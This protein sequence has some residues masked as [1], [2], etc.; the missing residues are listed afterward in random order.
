MNKIERK[1]ANTYKYK[2]IIAV[3]TL[4]LLFLSGMVS[5]KAYALSFI[6][7]LPG[8]NESNISSNF[9]WRVLEGKRGFHSGLDIAA[10][11]Q[12]PIVAS[13]DGT[14]SHA[15]AKGTYGNL[16]EIDHGGG[17][18]TRYAHCTKILVSKGQQVRAGNTIALVGSTGHSTGPHLHFEVRINNS[19]KNPRNFVHSDPNQKPGE[20]PD[21]YNGQSGGGEN[22]SPKK[23]G[24]GYKTNGLNV[25]TNESFFYQGAPKGQ[26]SARNNTLGFI[27]NFIASI[28]KFLITLV[29][30]LIIKL[31][32]IGYASLFEVMITQTFNA[33]SGE[34][35]YIKRNTNSDLYVDPRRSVNVE[36][37]IYGRVELLNI[38]FFIDPIKANERMEG[39]TGTGQSIEEINR[40]AEIAGNAGIA[41]EYTAEAPDYEESVVG[42]LRK[43][44][45][46]LYY[47]VY[48]ISII[49]MLFM[50][51]AITIS[52]MIQQTAKKKAKLKEFLLDW[53]K[54]FG[55]L[56]FSVIYVFFIIKFNN[57]LLKILLDLGPKYLDD[58][59]LN[60]TA[61]IYETIRTRAYDNKFSIGVPAAILYLIL[62]WDTVKF[63]YIYIK[64]LV[65][66]MLL[67]ILGPVANTFQILSNAFNG[68]P[69]DRTSV[70]SWTKE[71]T[72]LVLLQTI[73]AALYTFI[74]IIVF[75][76]L[77]DISLINFVI[78][79]GLHSML[80][81]MPKYLKKIFKISD[82]TKS[83]VSD[84]IK[85]D[86]V[87]E[88][89]VMTNAIL[90]S[91]LT[92]ISTKNF[93]DKVKGIVG[94]GT[95]IATGTL[96]TV[97]GGI[98]RNAANF[99][100]FL[101]DAIKHNEK[102]E[103]SP[104]VLR[105]REQLLKAIESSFNNSGIKM[106]EDLKEKLNMYSSLDLSN[107]LND[108]NT[109]ENFKIASAGG[110]LEEILN[111]DPEFSKYLS[112]DKM[113]EKEKALKWGRVKGAA[114]NTKPYFLNENGQYRIFKPIKEY[115]LKTGKYEIVKP[116]SSEY[117]KKIGEAFG[118]EGEKFKED[119]RLLLNTLE[120]GLSAVGAAIAIP[121]LLGDLGNRSGFKSAAMGGL[122]LP[123][124]RTSK[125]SQFRSDFNHYVTPNKNL[126]KLGIKQKIISKMKF[127]KA[128]VSHKNAEKIL[129]NAE[130]E[131]LNLQ[132]SEIERA[133]PDISKKD[134]KRMK[135]ISVSKN[136]YDPDR[137]LGKT[138][139]LRREQNK[140]LEEI[141]A[142]NVLDME[143]DILNQSQYA[144]TYFEIKGDKKDISE[145]LNTEDIEEKINRNLE[146]IELYKKVIKIKE[147]AN[148]KLLEAN[149]YDKDKSVIKDINDK[150]NKKID[151]LLTDNLSK[152]EDLS[153]LSKEEIDEMHQ[154]TLYKI[155]S[156]DK[157][158][159]NKLIEKEEESISSQTFKIMLN[160]YKD[161]NITEILDDI[162]DG[163]LKNKFKQEIDFKNDLEIEED[164]SKNVLKLTNIYDETIEVE[165]LKIIGRKEYDKAKQIEE[166]VKNSIKKDK[167]KEILKENITE[168]QKAEKIKQ[169]VSKITD[170]DVYKDEN[171]NKYLDKKQKAILDKYISVKVNNA[172]RLKEEDINFVINT[173]KDN[174]QKIE[175]SVNKLHKKYMEEINKRTTIIDALKDSENQYSI[176]KETYKAKK[177]KNKTNSINVK[178]ERKVN[179]SKIDEEKERQKNL[180][181]LLNKFYKN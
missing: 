142:L 91:E 87:K 62:V 94:K 131:I 45:A 44:Y 174:S 97:G 136:Y 15:G 93:K 40:R 55:T 12:T 67:A 139:D 110:D 49:L 78:L 57:F 146:K 36:N 116:G 168:E 73:H 70:E 23:Y 112:Y 21:G 58:G 39:L 46:G 96:S 22:R 150:T 126:R 24:S 125:F 101:N 106:P 38:D 56:L 47:A 33:I 129:K 7:P 50:L 2:K 63:I 61:S 88:M 11:M 121:A 114:K 4:I 176:Y 52:S 124:K 173:W 167:I 53:L 72:Y 1:L 35:A 81:E 30:N 105:Q 68:K 163:N 85:S 153:T 159:L 86:P 103:Y 111:K 145:I 117:F 41:P 113:K 147:D 166:D 171:R 157:N 133:I 100:L 99:G 43:N 169:E 54:G 84:T 161:K 128:Y 122:L 74:M 8:K 149:L 132:Y 13:A 77:V 75:K 66:L 16:V 138:G 158:G 127:N 175:K 59:I 134:I 137:I 177:G 29:V 17:Y 123:D 80:Y 3:I 90:G 108:K 170:A 164:I 107:I 20:V 14:V 10:P 18:V 143:K 154:K 135:K 151:K 64:R 162:E 60:K 98:L 180:N 104:E 172:D 140:I 71:I 28:G 82:K 37:I 51:V 34:D 89:D 19:P 102:G 165:T 178:T 83:A 26:Y 148:K 48:G 25:I 179:K 9:G 109:L 95:K 65:Y 119:K 115:N 92:N 31:P 76:L 152:I 141:K 69:G 27:L 181:N 5:N 144:K 156:T 130:E 32:I 155:S 118:F 6:W 79:I 42:I 120:V 160:E